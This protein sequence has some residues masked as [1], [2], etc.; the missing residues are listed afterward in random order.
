MK[1]ISKILV[2]ILFSALVIAP[3]YAGELTVTGGATATYTIGGDDSGSGKNLGIANELDFSASGELDNGYTWNYQVQLDGASAAND[4]TRL[5]LGTDMGT[6]GLYVTE[7]GMS[8][9]LHGVGALGAGFDYISPASGTAGSFKTGYDV[10]GYSNIQYHTPSGMLPF[11]AQVKLGYVPDM[12]DTTQM[13]AKENNSA[14]ASHNTGRNLTQASVTLAPLDGLT[15]QGDIAGTSNETGVA[16]S[17]EEGVSANLGAKYTIGQVTV[18]YVEGGYQ[19]AVASSEITYYE[20]KFMGIQFDVNDSLSLSY[21][22]DESAKNARAAITVGNTA[23]TKTVTEM[24]QKSIQL[25]YTT[26][27]ATIGIA[28]VDVTNSDYT[29]GKEET[30]SVVSLAIAF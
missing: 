10:D 30:Q 13:S 2:G 7:G 22:V 24:E 12:N 25:A 14:P 16:V 28:Q 26:G 4:D 9:E 5:E 6:I 1:K 21:N 8:K 29:A 27:G 3:S 20:N 23:G 11:G 18:G 15:I 17:T 19:P